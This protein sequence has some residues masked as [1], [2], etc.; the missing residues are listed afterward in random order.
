HYVAWSNFSKEDFSPAY[1]NRL[2]N[3]YRIEGGFAHVAAYLA[4]FDI[5]G[6]DPKA[7]P[8]QTPAFWEIVGANQPPEDAELAD[9][10]DALGK[11]DKHDKDKL[12]RPDV[13]TTKQL[14]A[15]AS[16]TLAEWLSRT[17]RA[18]PHRLERCG[19]VAVKNP[20]AKD[21]LWKIQATRQ[22]IYGRA[23]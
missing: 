20:D 7:P 11:L 19:Y 1:W 15:A 13:L 16:G 18:V 22:C 10:I 3:W 21:G 4:E 9:A 5:S 14:I 12:I 17:R 23:E 2:W 6:F 8:S